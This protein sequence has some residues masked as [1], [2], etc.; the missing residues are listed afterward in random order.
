MGNNIDLLAKH[1]EEWRQREAEEMAA[2]Q[3]ISIERARALLDGEREAEAKAVRQE[4][5][6]EAAMRK[7]RKE[8]ERAEEAERRRVFGQLMGLDCQAHIGHVMS[9]GGL[10]ASSAGNGTTRATVWHVVIDSEMQKG[11]LKREAGD[12]LCRKKSTFGERTMGVTGRDDW[13]ASVP[14]W[15]SCDVTCP[16][17]REIL[18]RLR[19]NDQSSSI[20]DGEG[21]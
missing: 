9:M 19:N 2:S 6:R 10:S 12:L 7:T 4:Q 16:R 13:E 15:E 1:V 5:E 14:L 17:C 8:K 20:S 11:R 21:A 3:C 18:E